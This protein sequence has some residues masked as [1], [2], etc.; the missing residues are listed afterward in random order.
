MSTEPEDFRDKFDDGGLASN[1]SLLDHFAG[2]AM[3]VLLKE[4]LLEKK[5]QEAEALEYQED[6]DLPPYHEDPSEDARDLAREAY[7]R[8]F[9]MIYERGYILLEWENYTK[10]RKR[11]E[12]SI[13]YH[14]DLRYEARK[15][16]E[17]ARKKREE[18]KELRALKEQKER[19]ASKELLKAWAI[20]RNTTPK[21]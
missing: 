20:R 11:A 1:M 7:F 5:Q 15:E 12:E 17:E 14:N 2:Q 10:D 3:I 19:E 4:S 6:D 9:Q 21:P 18:Q 8:A 16:R 13:T